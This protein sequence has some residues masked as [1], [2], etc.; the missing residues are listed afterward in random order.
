MAE[1]SPTRTHATWKPRVTAA[2]VPYFH[3]TECG[4]VV[5]GLDGAIDNSMTNDGERSLIFEPSYAHV[6][7]HLT[8][9]GKT[10]EQLTPI[11]AV[12]VADRFKINYQIMGGMNN[13]C[14]KVDWRSLDSACKPRWFALKT[15]TGIMTKYVQPKKWPPVVFALADEDAFA[16]CDKN[17][18]VECTF[19]CKRGMEIYAYVDNIGLVILPLDRMVAS[20][21]AGFD[22]FDSPHEIMEKAKAARAAKE[23]ESAEK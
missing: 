14:V 4:A 1:Y 18:C 9:C 21:S 11:P 15:F 2:H 19:R 8:C 16:Y 17:P 23:A 6:E 7:Y 13:N 12:D 10:M 5:Q 3:C 20:G 22:D